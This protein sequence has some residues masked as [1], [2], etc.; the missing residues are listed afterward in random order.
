MLEG[1][2]GLAELKGAGGMIPD[3]AILINPI[4]SQRAYK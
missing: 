2:Q 1:H 3:Q 4:L